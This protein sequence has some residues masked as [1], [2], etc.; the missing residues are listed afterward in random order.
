MYRVRIFIRSAP[1]SS[2]QRARYASVFGIP[3]LD[4]RLEIGGKKHASYETRVDTID[5]RLRA[6]VINVWLRPI[7]VDTTVS[8]TLITNLLTVPIY[9]SCI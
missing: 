4:Y 7:C 2:P 5:P 3:C 1:A 6:A 9:I 8:T